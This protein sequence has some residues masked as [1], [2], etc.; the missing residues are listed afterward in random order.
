VYFVLCFAV[1]NYK[2]RQAWETMETRSTEL[3]GRLALFEA[4]ATDEQWAAEVEDSIRKSKLT[5][6]ATLM[7]AMQSII[8]EDNAS[9]ASSK[10]VNSSK[11]GS[12][13]GAIDSIITDAMALPEN[14]VV[15]NV[16]GKII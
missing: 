3:E 15:Q 9:E 4:A 12:G 14:K 10:K 7:Q 11:G 2:V 13:N 1:Y 6:G 8:G 5:K 16:K